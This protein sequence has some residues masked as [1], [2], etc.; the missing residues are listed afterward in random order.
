MYLRFSRNCVL[1][2]TNDARLSRHDGK[3]SLASEIAQEQT[4][5]LDDRTTL[6]SCHLKPVHS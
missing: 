1:L 3:Q 5:T 6:L 2:R 4:N